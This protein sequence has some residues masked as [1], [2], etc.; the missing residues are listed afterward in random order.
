MLTSCKYYQE[1]CM[2]VY[3]V[4]ATLA[5]LTMLNMCL[6]LNVGWALIHVER[7]TADEL[8]PDKMN[9][10][11]RR[12]GV[13]AKRCPCCSRYLFLIVGFLSLIGLALGQIESVCPKPDESA[14]CSA[15][16]S[17]SPL[18]VR[19]VGVIVL[20]WS[21]IAC[22]GCKTK[23]QRQTLPFLY[24]PVE[25]TDDSHSSVIHSCCKRISRCCHP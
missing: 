20:L 10:C 21:L 16:V 8:A 11:T 23:S 1:K 6:M 22:L 14:F 2:A 18:P 9:A 25:E 3:A 4:C 13:V 19:D 12:W 7:L 5:A 15:P 24:N 17:Q